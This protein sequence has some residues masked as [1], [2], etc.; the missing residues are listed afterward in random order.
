VLRE[1]PR[2]ETRKG[3]AN[4]NCQLLTAYCLML[5]AYW[6]GFGEGIAIAIAIAN[7]T[8]GGG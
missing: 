5:T 8:E 4:C 3:P 1:N 2:L 7:E 6:G